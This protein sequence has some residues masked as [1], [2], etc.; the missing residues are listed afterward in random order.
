MGRTIAEARKE[1]SP[2]APKIV[3]IKI[4][5]DKIRDVIGPGG[6]MIRHIQDTS[7]AKIQV[8]DDGTIE[9][10]A[11]DQAA[12]DMALEMIRGLTEEPEVGKVYKGTVRGIQVFGAFVQI[13]PGRDGL[14]HISEIAEHRIREVRDELK[15]G[16]QLLVK[17]IS[18]EGN[19]I[20]FEA[21]RPSCATSGK[22][23]APSPSS[24]SR[25]AWPCALVACARR[26]RLGA[27]CYL[28]LQICGW[29]S[30]FS[31]APRQEVA[32]ASRPWRTAVLTRSVR[33]STMALVRV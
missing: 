7:G 22:K 17:V 26:R 24:T 11:V 15:E 16:D 1:I 19:K 18:I 31:P 9:I 30:Q 13:L 12:G 6:K 14:L 2:F 10:A 4:P 33:C 29:F 32:R 20:L 8:E 21:A 25:G 5:V 23:L 3:Q 28:A 27:R